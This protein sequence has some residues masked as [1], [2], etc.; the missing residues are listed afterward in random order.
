MCKTCGAEGLLDFLEQHFGVDG[1]G[2]VVVHAGF[3]G[4][5][6]Q[7][8][9]EFLQRGWK[10]GSDVPV[11]LPTRSVLTVQ[12]GTPVRVELFQ[13]RAEALEAAGLQE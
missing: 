4:G 1:L 7:V 3:D 8:V 5:D 9:I 11:E 2:E 6:D 13:N 12:N 10:S